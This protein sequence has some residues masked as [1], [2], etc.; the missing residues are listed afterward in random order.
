MVTCKQN[1]VRVVV[2]LEVRGDQVELGLVISQ[3]VYILRLDWMAVTQGSD[4][5]F[6][7]VRSLVPPPTFL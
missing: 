3:L 1:K 7:G 5:P 2:V 6:W 4:F